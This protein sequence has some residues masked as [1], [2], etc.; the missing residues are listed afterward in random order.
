MHVLYFYVQ[1]DCRW[2]L[3]DK[4]PSE[5]KMEQVIEKLNYPL[6]KVAHVSEC[7]IFTILI[8]IALK[9]SG[10][11]GIRKYIITLTIC[12]IY[13]C[14]DEYHQTFVKWRT[15]QFTDA[16]IDTAGGVASCLIYYSIN[17]IINKNNST[18]NTTKN[19]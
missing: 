16:L 6:R 17:K 9:N 7:F 5:N 11:K 19:T 3:T 12:F 15:G 13:A 10:V 14:T 1:Y 2:I 18:Y 8:L 4:Y